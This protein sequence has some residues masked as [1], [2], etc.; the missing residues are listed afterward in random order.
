[1]DAWV[2]HLL[3][4]SPSSALRACSALASKYP[5]LARE[6]FNA[7]FLSCWTE[8]YDVYQDD[9]IHSLETTFKSKNIPP[10]IVQTLLNLAEFMEHHDKAL[11][12]DIRTLGDLALRCHAYA[13]ALHYKETEFH[14]SPGSSIE[15]LISINNKLQQPEAAQGL[16]KFAQRHHSVELKESWYEKLQRWEDAL[17]AYER[18]QL[19]VPNSVECALGRMRCLR[20]LGEWNRLSQLAQ[21]LWERTDG[22]MI[23]RK[24]IAPLAAAAAFNL[25][26]WD[27]M[28]KFVAV[29]PDSHENGSFYR[30]ILAVHRDQFGQAR[31]YIE[32]SCELLDTSLTALIGESYD[33]AYHSIVKLQQLMELNEVILYK[34]GT[35][36]KRGLIRKMWK[37]RLQGCK[38]SVEV[39]QRMLSVRSMVV[40]YKEDIETWIEFSSLCRR[41][42]RLHLSLKVLTQLLGVSP[43]V[44]VKRP[45][46]PLPRDYP[47]MTFACLK[48]LYSAGHCQEAFIR[49]QEL[50]A[51]DVL[52]PDLPRHDGLAPKS[53][54][55]L[56]AR[57]YLK[58]GAWLLAIREEM[59]SA[60]PNESQDVAAASDFVPQ[61]LN[62]FHAATV[63]DSQFYKAW[64]EWSAM[65]FR[66]VSNYPTMLPK[67]S[68]IRASSHIVPAIHGFV[69]SIALQQSLDNTSQ[70]VLRL[71]A[72]WFSHGARRDVEAALVQGI[73]TISIDTWLDVIPQMIA[74]IDN[75]QPLIRK[76]LQDLLCKIGKAH[77]QALVYPLTVA[78]KSQ[79]ESRKTAAVSVL[80]NLRLH[81]ATL[82]E[83]ASMV[84]HEL[85]RVAILWHEMWHEGIEEASRYW[86]QQKNPE[87]CLAVLA[88]LHAMM[89]KG[90]ATMREM[91]FQQAF[92]AELNEA[93]ELTK[94]Y[95]N[96]SRNQDYLKR[97]WDF[98]SSVFRKMSKQIGTLTELELHDVSPKLLAARDMQL[99]VPGTYK[100]GQPVVRIAS[101]SPLLRVIDSKQHPRRLTICGS[102][103]LE[104]PFLLKG[105]ED[106]R[107]DERVMQLFGLVNTL[108]AADPETSQAD[109]NIHRYSVVPLSPNS[110]IIE[111]VPHCD[112]VHALIKQYR[113]NRKIMLNIE[114]R[115]ML[116]MA[117]DYQHLTLIQ[118]VE[119]FE[120]ALS[121]TTGQDLSKVL[122]LKSPNAEVWLDRRTNYSRSLAVMSMV[123]YILGLGDRHPCNLMLDRNSG[124][125]IHIDFG[126]CFEVAMHRDKYPEKVPFRLTRMLV[127]AMD[128]SGIEGLYRSTCESV[129][130]VLRKNQNSVMAI[131]EAFVYDPLV[132]WKL[133]ESNKKK[134]RKD[135]PLPQHK[136]RYDEGWAGMAM[137]M[138]VGLG[139]GLEYEDD[140]DEKHDADHKA[141]NNE[142]KEVPAPVPRLNEKALSVI[143]RVESKLKGRDFINE[144]YGVQTVL[145]VPAQVQKLILEATSHIN[146]CQ[147]Y[148]GW[149]PFW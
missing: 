24:Q 61:V 129:M 83:Q 92:G 22:D 2:L 139:A 113:D 43:Y 82:V 97:A 36:E 149:C 6:L 72:L 131:L 58:L 53:V 137:A 45:D 35:E 74:R 114:Q 34:T 64:H 121:M 108:L 15:T 33:R 144:N 47:Q 127:K 3:K 11:P 46:I 1:V 31:R 145:D 123:G 60:N 89:E 68:K 135:L 122:W 38:R 37:Q 103:G 94:K 91:A 27:D 105:H 104:Y 81:S 87:A 100:T 19:E 106:M 133:L 85:V 59:A 57:C 120:Y 102:D 86:F 5:P 136:Q 119:V 51:S 143:S 49:L 7:A 26:Q 138:G 55:Q 146:L 147:S 62:Y 71:L 4:E 76:L 93:Y 41:S 20:S 88:P 116:K 112:T 101:F 69:R 17:E 56:K 13:K 28:D 132:N 66:V 14:T 142:S 30:A 118:K 65:N 96:R 50:V 23:T 73:N 117:P 29:I 21:D 39:W 44:F 10:E 110:G 126:D 98:Y 95:A 109:L 125:I 148:I 25:R 32:R 78:S 140:E 54:T 9:L 128:V 8:L 18:K 115:L 130:R 79:P 77:P 16:L 141:E 52:N 99:A 48:H 111:W 40:S 90:P 134:S 84:S 75:P 42:N 107:Q 63:C 67:G 12:I 70:D 124:K 80:N